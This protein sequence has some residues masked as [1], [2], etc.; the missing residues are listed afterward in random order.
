MG[1]IDDIREAKKQALQAVGMT[2]TSNP[3]CPDKCE[4]A[5]KA[6]LW[7]ANNLNDQIDVTQIM[8]VCAKCGKSI[9][10]INKRKETKK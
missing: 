9:W 8:I 10:K 3:D 6:N 2:N 5:K 7:I 1:L 4:N